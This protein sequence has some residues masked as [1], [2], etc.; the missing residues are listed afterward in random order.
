MPQYTAQQT[1][2]KNILTSLPQALGNIEKKQEKIEKQK[3]HI[4]KAIYLYIIHVKT[5]TL[6]LPYLFHFSL[7]HNARNETEDSHFTSLSQVTSSSSLPDIPLPYTGIRH[8][9]RMSVAII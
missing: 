3:S 5:N 8:T 6:T 4:S 2:K 9:S 1:P 7:Q